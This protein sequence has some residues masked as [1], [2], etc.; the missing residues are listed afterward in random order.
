MT[1]KV[2]QLGAWRSRS[3]TSSPHPSTSRSDRAGRVR[4]I[5]RNRLGLGAARTE[6]CGKT[7]LDSAALL[8][9]DSGR[10]RVAGYD[11][12]RDF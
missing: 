11:T 9:P 4:A 8:A 3:S 6:R 7:T 12:V 1:P 10:A 2:D 5:V